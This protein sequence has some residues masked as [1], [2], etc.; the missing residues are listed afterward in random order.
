MKLTKSLPAILIVIVL[1]LF[2]F[3]SC[4]KDSAEMPETTP[5]VHIDTIFPHDYFP[6]YP[7]SSWTYDRPG[8][9]NVIYT[10][11]PNYE[12][13]AR[14]S[15]YYPVYDSSLFYAPV[16]EGN[17]VNRGSTTPLSNFDYHE[18]RTFFPNTPTLGSWFTSVKIYQGDDLEGNIVALDDTMTV[19]NIFYDSV[20]EVHYFIDPLPW[21]Y[22]KRKFAKNVGLV[23]EISYNPIDTTVTDHILLDSY[24]INF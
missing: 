19:N 12:L 17:V 16:W 3:S 15:D 13:F 23:E 20:M 6:T 7:G 21:P 1:W 11:D 9:F 14:Y 22:Y 10:T 5:V 24:S 18:W 8:G 2:T 4:T